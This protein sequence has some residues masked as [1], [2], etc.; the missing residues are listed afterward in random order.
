[1]RISGLAVAMIA[2]QNALALS[3]AD[4]PTSTDGKCRG[5]ALSGGSNYGAWEAGILWGLVNYGNPADFTWDVVSGVSAGS[6]N[7]SA[8]SVFATGDEINMTQFV[9]DAWANLTSH[10]IW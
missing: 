10:D 6:I 3:E 8:T 2:A 9:S 7:T 5:L 4:M 1:M